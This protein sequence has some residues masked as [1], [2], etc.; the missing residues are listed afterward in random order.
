MKNE[1]IGIL[2]NTNYSSNPK[3]IKDAL[4]SKALGI[5]RQS[6]SNPGLSY[7][8]KRTSGFNDTIY[9]GFKNH[10]YDLFEYSRIIDTEAIVAKA[11]ERQR[12][13]IFKNGYYFESNNPKNVEYIKSRIREIEYVTGLTFRNFIE[14]MAYNLVMFHNSY[15]LMVRNEKKSTGETVNVGNKELEPIAGWFNLPTETIQR[16]LKENG[17]VEMYKQYIDPATFRLFSPE[18]VRHLKYNARSGFT[19]GTPPLEAVKDDI[20][21]LRRIEES[22][23]TLIYKG[24]FPMIHVKV[25]T[26]SNPAKILV[27]GSDE[28]EK[29]GYVMQELDEYGGITTS[30]R[31][32]VKAIG[33]ESLA[34]RVE[35]YLEYF[36]DRVML[37]LGVSD[38]DMGIGDSSGKA[39]GQIISQ[40]LKEAVINK[41]DA[42]SEFITHVLFKPLLVESGMYDAEYLIPEEDLVKFKFNHVDQDARIKIESHILNMFNSGLLSINEARLEIG[43]K[44]IGDKEISRIGKDKEMILPTY[45]VETAKVA[46]AAAAQSKKENSSG[47]K[48]KADGAKKA[49]ASKTNPKN[50]FSDSLSDSLF[51]IEEIRAAMPNKALLSEYIENHIKLVVDI[52][53]S[54]MDNNVKDIVSVFSD[55]LY[56]AGQS[57]DI[58]DSEIE[59]LLIRMYEL[60]GGEQ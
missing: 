38:I 35:S 41:Q 53:D 18:K 19:M 21:A 7:F 12:A 26:E 56:L 6:L 32:E 15:I 39:T 34:L 28:V 45:Q 30:E 37:G 27:D 10:E 17:D 4:S 33:S 5:K 54:Q 20:L 59:D 2:L 43:Y 51:P 29:M 55:S 46:A 40:T 13:L 58:S 57:E 24:I 14:E 49:S 52:S 48:T 50:Q 1:D 9:S 16:K 42:I 44:E 11:F 22:V 25:G 47:N 8:G 60:V 36:K 3:V 31:V 23:E